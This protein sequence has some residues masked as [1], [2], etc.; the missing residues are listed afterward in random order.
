MKSGHNL[1]AAV[2]LGLLSLFPL[3]AFNERTLERDGAATAVY[4]VIASWPSAAREAAIQLIDTNG[5]P[6]EITASALVWHVGDSRSH[7]L[8]Y[9]VDTGAVPK[10][11]VTEGAG[12]MAPTDVSQR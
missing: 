10:A 7:E 11:G 5:V 2:A 9:R 8:I 1:A 6:D 12:S 4:E 3:F